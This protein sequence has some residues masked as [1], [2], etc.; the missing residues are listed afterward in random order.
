MKASRLDK[1]EAQLETMESS[2]LDVLAH[3]LPRV[4]HSGEMLFFNSEFGPPSIQ[5]HW[6]PRES[7]ILL[8]LAKEA[9]ALRQQIGLPFDGSVGQLY[10]SA[11]GEADDVGNEHRRGP[12]QLASGLL[13][14]LAAATPFKRAL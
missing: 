9:I 7:E 3:A 12:R 13:G 2:L 11:C 8:S 5:A 14:E 6:L 10:L 1:L 4:A